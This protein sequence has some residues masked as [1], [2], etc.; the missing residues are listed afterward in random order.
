MSRQ[1][2]VLTMDGDEITGLHQTEHQLQFFLG[3]VSV[4][5]YQCVTGVEYLCSLA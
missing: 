2:T 1:V 4:Y 3:C 5:M